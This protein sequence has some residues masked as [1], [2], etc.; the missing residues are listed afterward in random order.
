MP[1]PARAWWC[2]SSAAG[3]SPRTTPSRVFPAG[4]G[5]AK[6]VP[7]G[8]DLRKAPGGKSPTFLVAAMKDS[9]SGNLDRIQ[10]VK[11]WLDKDSKT[12]EKVYDVVWSGD[13][14]PGADG[15]V[16]PVGN[17][18]DVAKATWKNT[19]G[20]PE[21]STTW[22]DPDFDREAT[23]LLLRPRHR[24][25][26]AALDRLR[27]AAF[28][29]QDA[30]GSSDDDPGARLHLADLVYAGEVTASVDA[31]EAELL[32]RTAAAFPAAGR[33]DLRGLQLRVQAAAARSRGRS[34]SRRDRSSIS[35]PA[36]RRPGSAR[37]RTRNW[38]G[39]IR[40]RVREEVYCREAM[41][42]GLD[43][44]DT[45]IRRRLRQKMEFV[46]DDIAAQTEP[47]DADLNAYLQAH[48]D[49]F[50]VEQRFT[51]RQVYLNPEKHGENLARDAAQLLAQLKQA[52]GKADVSALGD[53][54]LLEHDFTAVPASEVA[55]Q[56]GEE[57]AAKLGGLAARPMAGAG[58]VRLRRA[59]GVRQRT[60]G[61]TPA[62]AGG[63]A[64]RRASRVGQRPAAGSEREVLPGTAQALHGDHRAARSRR[65]NETKAG[66]GRHETRA[67][68]S[69][70]LLATFVCARRSR[71]R[72]APPISNCARPDRRPTTCCGRCRA[73]REPAPRTLRGASG[74]LHE[75]HRA[76]RRRWST[77]PSPS[78]GP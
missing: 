6:G 19:I 40:D 50:R 9:Y 44:D 10:I 32:Q 61:R 54:F 51:F 64:R 29:N 13:R 1:R 14:K 35:P 53:S 71:T 30:A 5:Y 72:C 4:V 2:A 42:L 47:T 58:R 33:C 31:H 67:P 57:F 21:L 17:T 38:Q 7:M 26:D 34:S 49:T 15:K 39:L 18:V 37:P 77:T 46:S 55:K 74:G 41:A 23:R 45:V 68:H 8:G 12:Q 48:P 69:S 36:S 62:R 60:H 43:K 3:T 65:Q 16:P 28:R 73:G 63:R 27:G 70:F 66:E 56:F 78:A 22:T 76:A 25:S 20:S 75:R 11:G 59:S 52:G 24:D